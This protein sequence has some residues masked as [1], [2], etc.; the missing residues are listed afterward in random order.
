VIQF[1]GEASVIASDRIREVADQIPALRGLL[2]KY[3]QFFLAH[4]QQTAACN[5][6]HTVQARTCKWLLRMHELAGTD[7]PVTQEFLACMMGVR[8]TSV[9]AVAGELQKAGMISYRRSHLHII[10]LEQIRKWRANA[11]S[12]SGLAMK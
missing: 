3:E 11:M 4:V 9:T 8:R 10:D 6:V 1:P 5:A 12:R 2:V 7:L